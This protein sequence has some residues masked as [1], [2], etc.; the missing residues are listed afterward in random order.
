MHTARNLLHLSAFHEWLMKKSTWPASLDFWNSKSPAI[1][2]SSLVGKWRAGLPLAAKRLNRVSSKIFPR[3]GGK[4]ASLKLACQA[5]NGCLCWHSHGT[6]YDC[7]GAR[8]QLLRADAAIISRLK[9]FI[10]FIWALQADE[11]SAP[12]RHL[13]VECGLGGYR[14]P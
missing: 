3:P 8:Q 7:Q 10:E 5:D 2:T 13:H 12:K 4:L 6:H 1:R 11:A 14:G 9:D